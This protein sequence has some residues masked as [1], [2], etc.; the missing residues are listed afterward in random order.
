MRK[1]IR[2]VVETGYGLGLL[3]LGEAKRSR[4]KLR[5]SLT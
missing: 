5:K 1:T 4:L 3:S 2:K